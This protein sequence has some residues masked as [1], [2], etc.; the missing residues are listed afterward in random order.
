VSH[1]HLRGLNR[2]YRRSGKEGDVVFRVEDP[3]AFVPEIDQMLATKDHWMARHSRFN[4]WLRRP[5]Y[6]AFL[7]AMSSGSHRRDALTL[8]TLRLNGVQIAAEP[9]AV[10]GT[11]VEAL[12]RTSDPKCRRSPGDILLQEIVRVGLRAWPRL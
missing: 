8:F 4:E 5:V 10:D 1:S 7:A 11:Q 2:E 9:S 6:R 12:V 3:D